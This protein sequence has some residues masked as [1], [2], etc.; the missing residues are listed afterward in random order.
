MSTDKD[1]GEAVNTEPTQDGGAG[2]QDGGAGNQDGGA[3]N[4][5]GG[6]G[7]QDGGAGQGGED[8]QG[9]PAD[10][11]QQ[12]AGTPPG[13]PEGTGEAPL[14]PEQQQTQA[15]QDQLEAT[16][17]EAQE[18]QA[19]LRAV[20]KAYTDLQA[21]MRGF[22]ERQEARAKEGSEL[23][24]F[25]L[26][27]TFFDPVMN[28][29]R[30]MQN[31]PDT[32]DPFISGLEMVQKQFMDALHRLGLEEVPGEGAPFDPQLHEALA[33]TPVSDPSQD[34]KVLAVHA[35]GYSVKGRVL[36]AAQVVVGKYHEAEGGEA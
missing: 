36:Q 26:A 1:L 32:D 8:P 23:Q 29:K 31:A 19:R 17:R 9:A 12:P 13:P 21:E 4:Q 3:G 11:V 28:L 20:S 15:L 14:T 34:G 7:N 35:T 27:K 22:R 10:T 24:A 33:V 30:S 16:Q 25:T 5:G 6:A 2:N 18:A